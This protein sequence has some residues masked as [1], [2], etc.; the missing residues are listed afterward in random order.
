MASSAGAEH[1][2]AAELIE[3]EPGRILL[4]PVSHL[5]G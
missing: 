2:P 3:I 1:W 4:R 5:F